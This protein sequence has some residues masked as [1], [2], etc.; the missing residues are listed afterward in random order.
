VLLLAAANLAAAYDLYLPSHEVSTLLGLSRE[1]YYVSAGEVRENALQFTIPI[2][3]DVN[4]LYFVWKSPDENV[5]YDIKISTSDPD[6]L[7]QPHLNVSHSGVIPLQASTWRVTLP[8]TRKKTADVLVT[9]DIR[10]RGFDQTHDLSIRRNKR[11]SVSDKPNRQSGGGV[12]FVNVAR[13]GED[14]VDSPPPHVVFLGLLLAALAVIAL[15]V[16]AIVSLHLRARKALQYA[17]EEEE[18]LDREEEAPI[19]P[20]MKPQS[21]GQMHYLQQP[22]E[23]LRQQ[24]QQQQL[25]SHLERPGSQVSESNPQYPPPPPSN[26][27]PPEL[28]SLRGK[29]SGMAALDGGIMSDAESRVT[30]WVQS[31]QRVAEQGNRETDPMA[32]MMLLEVD[33]LR[34]KLGQ[35]LQEGTFGRVYQST[36]LN[37]DE[38]EDV[39]VKTVVAGSSETQSQIMI[40][41]GTS[42]HGLIQQH[43][44]TIL[45]A[46]WDGT[47][48]ML[49]YPYAKLGNL[50]RWLLASGQ[51]GVSTHVVVSLGLQMLKAMQHLHK[52]KIIHKDIATRNC[53]L[54]D[55]HVLKLG[56]N[57][58]SRDLFPSDY[59]CL[60][61]N[62][63]RPIKW[64]PVEAISQKNYS[65]ASDVWSFGVF[66]W[67]LMTRAQ[68]PFADIDPFEMEGYILEGYRLHQPMNCPDQL[69]SVLTSCWGTRANER[70]GVSA[71]HNHL[72][73][74]QKQLQQFV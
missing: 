8:C 16:V 32:V 56:D 58:L 22:C 63:N 57:A 71:L 17:S 51:A 3:D 23:A 74:L 46:T 19:D 68:Q 67:E 18:R 6:A 59:H 69:Y 64:L 49:V 27:P 26:P 47:S 15:I 40:S 53:L 4:K 2:S 70:A 24:Q 42:L 25:A 30:D 20:V 48:P 45:A 34:L 65:R 29:P 39:L 44:Q 43:L 9:I 38:E 37:D 31:Q 5:R 60:G 7:R 66:L 21:A 72:G 33:R 73:T 62:E 36:L 41:E 14:E 1:L 55:G 50:K 28:P 13:H 12:P 54:G 35:L 52:R 61:D 10:V 11:C